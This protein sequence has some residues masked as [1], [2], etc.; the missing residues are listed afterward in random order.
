MSEIEGNVPPFLKKD[1]RR[2]RAKASGDSALAVEAAELF[3]Q[4]VFLA[5]ELADEQR[6]TQE[7]QG[8]ATE[9]QQ[10]ATGLQDYNQYL[11]RGTRA[12]AGEL[13]DA[14]NQLA[15]V[16]QQ[17]DKAW[18]SGYLARVK[19]DAL[20]RIEARKRQ[21]E[22]RIDR[23]AVNLIRERVTSLITTI[24]QMVSSVGNRLRNIF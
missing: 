17:L 21:R 18:N 3:L 24:P 12:Y 1:S 6:L 22:N 4:N 19:E 23:W 5:A 11:L 13:N 20:R 14:Y 15:E 8:K 16:P 9:L 10:V 7:Q 2:R